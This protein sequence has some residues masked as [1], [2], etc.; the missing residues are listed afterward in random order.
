MLGEGWGNLAINGQ[1]SHS[2]RG[3]G[4]YANITS[5]FMLQKLEL[6]TSADGLLG[7]KQNFPLASLRL[8]G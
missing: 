5:R 1:V 3:G 7:S 8:T 6:S 4:G 2:G